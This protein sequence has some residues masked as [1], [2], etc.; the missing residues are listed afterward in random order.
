M[1]VFTQDSLESRLAGE[2]PLSRAPVCPANPAVL[3]GVLARRG[4]ANRLSQGFTL[5]EM[6]IVISIIGILVSIVIPIYKQH[7]LRAREATLKEDL[8]A[9]RQSIDQ[10]TQDKN[11]APQSLDD[12]VTAGYLHFLPK[13]PFTNAND[14]WQPVSDDSIQQLNQTDT[15]IVDV[16]S[17]SKDM[18]SEGTTYDTW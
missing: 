1:F 9:M 12:L 17:G 11:K 10:Y 3:R 2:E 5:I 7:I 18:S 4:F 6:I 13:D 8:Y 15:G 14:T 16:H